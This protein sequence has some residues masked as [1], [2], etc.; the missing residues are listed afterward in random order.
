MTKTIE[1]LQVNNYLLIKDESKGKYQLS[2]HGDVLGVMTI[3]RDNDRNLMGKA[4]LKNRNFTFRP[5]K[6][7]WPKKFDLISN[8]SKDESTFRFGILG[9]TG[10]MVINNQEYI[11][12]VDPGAGG[13]QSHQVWFWFDKNNQFKSMDLSYSGIYPKNVQTISETEMNSCPDG[14]LLILFAQY[15]KAAYIG[16]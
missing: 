2:F 16:G 13:L 6:S 1:E 15:I 8:E 4:Y 11:L 9:F 10:K 7:F 14:L 12:R 5:R 3:E